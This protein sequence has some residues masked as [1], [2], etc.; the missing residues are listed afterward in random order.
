MGDVHL[1]APACRHSVCTRACVADRYCTRSAPVLTRAKGNLGLPCAVQ[2]ASN[3]FLVA[4][5]FAKL[6]SVVSFVVRQRPPLPIL[7]RMRAYRPP[8][9]TPWRCKGVCHAACLTPGWACPCVLLHRAD[10]HQRKTRYFKHPRAR[11]GGPLPS[12]R[13]LPLPAH[14]SS[15]AATRPMSLRT[16]SSRSESPARKK[17]K[18]CCK[19]NRFHKNITRAAR[20]TLILLLDQSRLSATDAGTQRGGHPYPPPTH[21]PHALQGER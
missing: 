15:A 5:S 2:V 10:E 13:P 19:Y 12:A 8:G 4:I 20:P 21:T 9:I 7:L 1:G 6:V 11:L 14:P 18:E 3:F 17:A 16:W